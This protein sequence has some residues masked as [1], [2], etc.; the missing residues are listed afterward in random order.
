VIVTV[1]PNPSL[2]R[3]LELTELRVGAV[4]RAD[5][6]RV[7]PGGKG[8]NVARALLAN[9]H[10]TRAV[11]PTGGHEGDQLLDALGEL[12]LEVVAVPLADP[13]RTNISLVEAD[14][15]TTKINASGPTLTPAELDALVAVSLDAARGASWFAACGS[16]PPGAPDTLYADLVREVHGVGARVVVDASG[17]AFVAAVAAGPDLVKPNADELAAAVGAELHTIGDVLAA[18][19]QLRGRGARTVV[20]SLG[21]DGAVL[22]DD[23]GSWHATS[24][25]ITPRSTVGAG[26][27]VVAGL[28]SADRLGPGALVRGVAFGVAAALLPGTQ[29]PGPDDLHLDDVEVSEPDP[30]RPLREPGGTR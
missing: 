25:P 22:V 6:V 26:D 7:E 5:R 1:T 8:I 20:V 15:T 23:A 13:V 30:A 9:G 3:T 14:G 2:D 4:V 19:G 12:G 28:L 10:P 16:L 29:L 17:P 27:S 21:A 11:V 18:A 24:P